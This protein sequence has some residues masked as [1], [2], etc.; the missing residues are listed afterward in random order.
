[1]RSILLFVL[2]ALPPAAVMAQPP[3]PVTLHDAIASALATSG[4]GAA[5]AAVRSGRR[6]ASNASASPQFSAG[7]AF[8]IAPQ[9]PG[10]AQT[11]LTEQL[12]ID[13]GSAGTRR[14]RLLLARANAA[15]AQATLLQSRI[16]AMQSAATAFFAVALDQSQLEAAN[17]SVALGERSLDAAQ[18][19]L[20]VGL[21]PLVDVERARAA[22][23]N[24]QADQA[25]AVAALSGDRESLASLIGSSS[26]MVKLPGVAPLPAVEQIRTL[27]PRASPLA[28]L[29]RASLDTAQASELLARGA[30]Q[31][32]LS[33]GAGVSQLRQ[34]GIGS[35]GPALNA[36][37][38]FP[39]SSS[40]GRASVSAAHAQSVAARTAYD[41][42]ASDAVR[43]ALA[44]RAQAA[45]AAARLPELNTALRE[46][47]RVANAS[48][49]G[50]RLGAVSSAD[51]VTALTQLAATR[52]ALAIGTVDAS[53]SLAILKITLGVEPQ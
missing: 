47:N 45:A 37:L 31:P 53:R 43:N 32:A 48:L 6:A 18:D 24:A 16:T 49:A 17:E 21:A 27:A 8:G 7:V 44:L 39:I 33:V 36:G 41:A 26:G 12:G 22:L 35:N 38:N 19:R 52:R 46:A 23:A 25:A 10:P 11:S 30:L 9:L 34:A 2:L 1:M 51:L 29:A 13:F 3:K 40:I 15:Q 50:Y 5:T 42:L 4:I 14:G 28:V 20:R